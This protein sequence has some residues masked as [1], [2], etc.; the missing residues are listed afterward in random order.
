M[1]I[2]FISSPLVLYHYFS[3]D[4]KLLVVLLP[5]QLLYSQVWAKII[6]IFYYHKYFITICQMVRSRM[7]IV[8]QL[9]YK[10]WKHV[11]PPIDTKHLRTNAFYMFRSCNHIMYIGRKRTVWLFWNWQVLTFFHIFESLRLSYRSKNNLT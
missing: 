8:K 3:N 6:F 11:A 7:L 1:D 5:Q 2:L 10:T 4:F 9:I